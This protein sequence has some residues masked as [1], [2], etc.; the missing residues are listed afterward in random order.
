[1][2]GNGDQGADPNELVAIQDLISAT[3]LPPDETFKLLH[4]AHFGEALRGV[5]FTPGTARSR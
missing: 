5:S 3:A 1:M 2:S 4:K